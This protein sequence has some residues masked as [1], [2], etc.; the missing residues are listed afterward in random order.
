MLDHE[1]CA[2]VCN[3]IIGARPLY[4]LRQSNLSS[5][6]GE[7]SIA[8]FTLKEGLALAVQRYWSNLAFLVFV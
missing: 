8:Y 1:V 4:Q 5:K 3:M 2:L 7:Q 6:L